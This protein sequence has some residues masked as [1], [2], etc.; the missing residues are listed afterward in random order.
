MSRRKDPK[1]PARPY[2]AFPWTAKAMGYALSLASEIKG[3]GGK[4]L[5]KSVSYRTIAAELVNLGLVD[6]KP[7]AAAVRRMVLGLRAK[8][9]EVT[10]RLQAERAVQS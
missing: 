1:K 3:Q 7:S 4:V 2:H 6:H 10:K 8:K 5:C 9:S